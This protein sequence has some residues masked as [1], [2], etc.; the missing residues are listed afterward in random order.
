[1]KRYPEKCRICNP[2]SRQE[3]K[4]TSFNIY[5]QCSKN[6]CFT[7]PDLFQTNIVFYPAHRALYITSPLLM[8]F[9][10]NNRALSHAQFFPGLQPSEAFK[11]IA[12]TGLFFIHLHYQQTIINGNECNAEI[13]SF[14]KQTLN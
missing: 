9:R 8:T 11:K 1:M 2:E 6:I 5:I 7:Y 3:Y 10:Q 13:K 14:L 12:G 4:L